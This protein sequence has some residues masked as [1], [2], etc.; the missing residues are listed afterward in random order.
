[1]ST[2]TRSDRPSTTNKTKRGIDMLLSKPRTREKNN[3]SPY[4][5]STLRKKV[6]ND[7]R[8]VQF[9]SIQQ[10][11]VIHHPK[12]PNTTSFNFNFKNSRNI[13]QH[14]S[15]NNKDQQYGQHSQQNNNKKTR[16][17]TTMAVARGS[18]SGGSAII[19]ESPNKYSRRNT[20]R[21]K[22]NEIYINSS[23]QNVIKY[24]SN[25]TSGIL[26]NSKLNNNSHMPSQIAIASRPNITRHR[27]RSTA[28]QTRA[29]TKALIQKVGYQQINEMV[30]RPS[31]NSSISNG[32]D[33]WTEDYLDILEN[34]NDNNNTDRK[35][36][37][38]MNNSSLMG[39]KSESVLSQIKLSEILI[40]TDGL[41]KPS[42]LRTA[43]SIQ[44]LSQFVKQE[45]SNKSN[46]LN[47]ALKELLQSIYYMPRS[48]DGQ[49]S[50]SPPFISKNGI[51]IP[52]AG[53]TNKQ[54]DDLL[55]KPYFELFKETK[56]M[57]ENLLQRN[58][59]FKQQ[60]QSIAHA[61][62]DRSGAMDTILQRWKR[63]IKLFVFL[64]WKYLTIDD[65][66]KNENISKLFADMKRRKKYR[67]TF[68]AW[69]NQAQSTKNKDYKHLKMSLDAAEKVEDELR[70][71]IDQMGNKIAEQR[72]R[73]E[74]MNNINFQVVMVVADLVCKVE[75]EFEI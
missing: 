28:E 29:L 27:P 24:M 54:D 4:R 50:S 46:L 74:A 39:F 20:R 40:A 35:F 8:M 21:N 64:Q 63:K 44:L 7:N 31:S 47:A 30:T 60:L 65:K 26:P 56:H 41:E 69:R 3:M 75:R 15:N 33:E 12:R 49:L 18:L 11:N 58:T 68:H 5:K 9:D 17:S 42:T 22:Q 36:K 73:L 55:N 70:D 57:N 51:E 16:P 19:Y 52:Q 13:R 48:N 34:C 62:K 59:Q 43:V 66:D 2:N 67:E 23:H 61:T 72:E 14:Q 37:I 38:K 6:L 71:K 45:S 32:L 1:M 53:N 10:K 25:I